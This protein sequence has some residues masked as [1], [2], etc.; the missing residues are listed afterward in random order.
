[1]ALTSGDWSVS[2][3][4]IKVDEQRKLVFF[5]GFKETPLEKH[6]YIVS[7]NRPGNIRRLTELGYTHNCDY[8]EVSISWFKMFSQGSSDWYR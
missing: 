4:S 7:I 5:H 8:F 6:G 3:H 1:M 2:Y